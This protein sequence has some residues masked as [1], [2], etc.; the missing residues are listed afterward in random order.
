MSNNHKGDTSLLEL[1]DRLRES[2]FSGLVEISVWFIENDESWAAEHR[3]RKPDALALT[4]RKP[5]AAVADPSVVALWK[6]LDHLVCTGE[7]CRLH[8]RFIV[9]GLHPRDVVAHRAGEQLDVLRQKADMLSEL[10]RIPMVD[11]RT[12]EPDLANIGD[13]KPD[14]QAA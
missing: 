3:A 14:H 6:M 11:W 8:N 7:R 5:N 2:R 9:D 4:A 12:I 1:K 10:S 13:R